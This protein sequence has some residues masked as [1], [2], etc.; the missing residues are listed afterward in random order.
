MS[1]DGGSADEH[2]NALSGQA[3]NPLHS[4]GGNQES[5]EA[6][7]L[8]TELSTEGDA[9]PSLSHPVQIHASG[10][11]SV[12]AAAPVPLVEQVFIYHRSF[13]MP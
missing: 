5:S 7:A 8:G 10:K 1:A 12:T 11:D 2:S 3:D 13:D 9:T 4:K 6:A